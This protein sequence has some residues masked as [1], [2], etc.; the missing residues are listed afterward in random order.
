MN[1]PHCDRVMVRSQG[2]E[3]PR[4]AEHGVMKPDAISQEAN[5]E[6]RQVAIRIPFNTAKPCKFALLAHFKRGVLMLTAYKGGHFR[7]IALRVC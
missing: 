5:G 6:G 4:C 3:H 2:E 7:S 1:C